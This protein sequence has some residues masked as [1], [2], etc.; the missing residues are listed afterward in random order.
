MHE[1]ERQALDAENS[2]CQHFLHAHQTTLSHAP[3]SV[4]EDLHSCYQ[5]LLGQ[6]SSWWCLPPA[7][8]HQTDG[9]PT[10]I[11]SPKKEP[12]WS[13][14]PKRQHSLTEV[15]GDTS[16]DEDSPMASQ[17]GLSSS[18]IGKMADWFSSLSPSHANAFCWDSSLVKEARACYFTTH[19]WDWAHGNMDDLSKIFWELAQDAGLLGESIHEL[20]QLWN[21]PED[22]KH[23]NYILQSLPKGLKF[24]RAVSTKESPKIMGL[25]G[26][27]DSNALRH[28]ASFTYCPW[29]GK[30]GQNEGTVINHLRTIHYKLGLVC[31]QC[32]SCPTVM[33]DALC[34]HGCHTCTS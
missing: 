8:V 29:C 27:H 34:W 18:K 7:Q 23:S 25:K 31:D 10:S 21:G 1:L 26:I 12:K 22:L 2:S 13:P 24:L 3:Q 32:Y 11:T 9:Q 28:F 20:Q 30:I 6:S 19:P 15:Q 14:L 33:S 16:G 5:I 4:K 17:E